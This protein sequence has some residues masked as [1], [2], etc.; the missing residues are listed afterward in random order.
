MLYLDTSALAKLYVAE[1]ETAEVV[2]WVKA[3]DEAIPFSSLHEIELASVLERRAAAGDLS[4]EAVRG[5]WRTIETDLRRG[6]LQRIDPDW[7]AVFSRAILMVRRKGRSGLR[8]LDSLHLAC[9]LQLRASCLITY[10]QIQSSAAVTEGME[11]R[12]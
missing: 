4:A 1:P 9:A 11:V 2:G 3:Q 8:S 7:A 5:I 10:D 12:P 6:I